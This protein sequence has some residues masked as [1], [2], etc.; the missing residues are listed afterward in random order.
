MR[1]AVD[2]TLIVGFLAVD[3]FLFHDFFKPG[4]THNFVQYLTGLLSLPVLIIAV[5]SLWRKNAAWR[6]R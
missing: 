3:W 2:V 1:T 5:Q 4:E 6:T